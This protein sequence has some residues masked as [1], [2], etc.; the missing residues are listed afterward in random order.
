MAPELRRNVDREGT[1]ILSVVVAVEV[2]GDFPSLQL[3]LRHEAGQTPSTGISANPSM[4]SVSLK[5]PVLTGRQREIIRG[6]TRSIYQLDG[7]GSRSAVCDLDR[8]CRV[9]GARSK[10]SKSIA[11][12]FPRKCRCCANKRGKEHR[13]R[14]GEQLEGRF[15]LASRHHGY[16]SFRRQASVKS[17]RLRDCQVRV[18]EPHEAEVLWEAAQKTVAAAE[19]SVRSE[20]AY[21]EIHSPEH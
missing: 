8:R 14:P 13:S 20:E 5:V 3:F 11:Q 9:G 19:A 7:R 17:L 18:E 10:R 12:P 6:R 15:R 4:S 16:R 21:Q 2:G 1:N